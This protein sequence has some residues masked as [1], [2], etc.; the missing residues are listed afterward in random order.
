MPI[1]NIPSVSNLL[2][3]KYLQTRNVIKIMQKD[4]NSYYILIFIHKT[5]K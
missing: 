3:R 2:V 1:R 5:L 4:H